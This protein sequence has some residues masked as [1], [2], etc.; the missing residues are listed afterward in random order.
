MIYVSIECLLPCTADSSNK[1]EFLNW[2]FL[3]PTG[4][5]SFRYNTHDSRVMFP[6]L[7]SKPRNCSVLILDFRFRIL[8]YESVSALDCSSLPQTV[9]GHH[10]NCP[11]VIKQIH[12]YENEKFS[13]PGAAGTYC[14]PASLMPAAAAADDAPRLSTAIEN[15]APMCH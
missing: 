2:E 15:E 3:I 10:S 12:I 6:T 5:S 9:A 13:G 8:N 7:N 11:R 14:M 1:F 4:N